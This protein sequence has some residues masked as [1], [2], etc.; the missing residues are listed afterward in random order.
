MKKD[1][2]PTPIQLIFESAKVNG[3][4]YYGEHLTAQRWEWPKSTWLQK[5]LA[6]VKKE[7]DQ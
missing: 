7:Q 5:R 6:E 1:N 2:K 4:A 3:G